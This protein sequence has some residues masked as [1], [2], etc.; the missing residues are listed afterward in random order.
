[1]SAHPPTQAKSRLRGVRTGITTTP[2]AIGQNAEYLRPTLG[3]PQRHTCAQMFQ[4]WRRLASQMMHHPIG[5]AVADHP[6][7]REQIYQALIR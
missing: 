5:R 7:F 3:P 4:F 2:A 6:L 1:V